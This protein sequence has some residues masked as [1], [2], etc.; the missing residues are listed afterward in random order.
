MA[1]FGAWPEDESVAL[2]P[3]R[4]AIQGYD[5]N[6]RLRTALQPT[7][8]A[9]S[10]LRPQDVELTDAGWGPSIESALNESNT[11]QM[12]TL[13]VTYYADYSYTNLVVNLQASLLVRRIPKGQHSAARL[14]GDYIPYLQEFRCLVYLPGARRDQP[15]ENAA[16]WSA[17]NG[18]LA[19]Q[20]LDLGIERVGSLFAQNLDGTEESTALWRRNNGRPYQTLTNRLG[21]V[22]EK[23]GTSIEFYSGRDDVLNYIET[24]EP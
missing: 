18:R 22:I 2:R 15:R 21:W 8:D 5:F 14:D 11:R 24:L 4:E 7:I 19:R 23:N 1:P 20:A 12:L 6:T 13:F 17:G 16:R 10:W 3:L 9:S